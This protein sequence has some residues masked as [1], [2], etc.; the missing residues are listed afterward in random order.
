MQ[1]PSLPTLQEGGSGGGWIQ[2]PCVCSCRYWA[3][4]FGYECSS[5][6]RLSAGH[7]QVAK[8]VVG[9][10]LTVMAGV[11]LLRRQQ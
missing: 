8:V 11:S 2:C 9:Q 1:L 4:S 6:L 7:V 3:S 10:S 5:S